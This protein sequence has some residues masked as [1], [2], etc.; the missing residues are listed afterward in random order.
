MLV[1]LD[2]I[3]PKIRTIE[4]NLQKLKEL[5]RFSP[6]EFSSDFMKEE[7]AKHLLQT[8]IEAMLDIGNHIISRSRFRTP[9][10]NAD[11]FLVLV[12]NGILPKAE[13]ET[14]T[15]M[16]RF[17]NRLVHFYDAVSTEDLYRVL[18]QELGDFEKF[19]AHIARFLSDR[20]GGG[21]RSEA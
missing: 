15:A 17:R 3:H 6:E 1:D 12:E 14:Y 16:A 9:T 10:S 4:D 13:I 18:R 5:R 19:I 21:G 11:V 2:K 20:C 8:A 7:S